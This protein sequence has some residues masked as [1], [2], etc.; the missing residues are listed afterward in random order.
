MKAQARGEFF[1]A[2]RKQFRSERTDLAIVRAWG[3]LRPTSPPQDYQAIFIR[4]LVST[5]L[6]SSNI[7][8]LLKP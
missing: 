4:G 5:G 2:L 6:D 8:A 1:L 7:N 3:T